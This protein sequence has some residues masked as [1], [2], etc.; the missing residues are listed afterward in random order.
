M[1]YVQFVYVQ[2]QEV[3]SCIWQVRGSQPVCVDGGPTFKA[4]PL[5]G[6]VENLW[7]THTDTHL[8]ISLAQLEELL[9]EGRDTRKGVGGGGGG[10]RKR[11][12]SPPWAPSS[13]S[14]G[15]RSL[16]LRSSPTFIPADPLSVLHKWMRGRGVG[17]ERDNRRCHWPNWNWKHRW[18]KGKWKHSGCYRQ[19][20]SAEAIYIFFT[21]RISN[22]F[23]QAAPKVPDASAQER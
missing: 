12:Y 7:S 23:K 1:L 2:Y 4:P 17:G 6:P 3:T 20:K 9:R 11:T 8:L 13:A 22:K 16:L 19:R 10:R 5:L 18:G 15:F 14:G 21:Y